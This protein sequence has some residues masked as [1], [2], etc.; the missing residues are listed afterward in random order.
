[1][2]SY[3]DIDLV[4]SVDLSNA[5]TAA[6]PVFHFVYASQ[7]YGTLFGVYA[8]FGVKEL[9]GGAKYQVDT[10]T[11]SL[12]NYQGIVNIGFKGPVTYAIEEGEGE[13]LDQV[14]NFGVQGTSTLL[15][16]E[17]KFAS[18]LLIEKGQRLRLIFKRTLYPLPGFEF[19]E[20]ERS[21]RNPADALDTEV[22]ALT[23]FDT[24]FQYRSGVDYYDQALRP[25]MRGAMDA[26]LSLNYRLAGLRCLTSVV[27]LH[28]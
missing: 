9:D 8:R 12:L 25:G 14:I 28:F 27:N 23:L 7:V 2:K 20:M 17:M 10:M 6:K 19:D 1:M 13:T 24:E 15:D 11:L 4:T 5:G 16:N 26:S 21:T 18:P 22:P 3:N